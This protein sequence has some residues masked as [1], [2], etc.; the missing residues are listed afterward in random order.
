[1]P[2][3]SED[4][5]VGAAVHDAS[6]G[7]SSRF[8][9]TPPLARTAKTTVGIPQASVLGER[10]DELAELRATLLQEHVGRKQDRLA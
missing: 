9:L 8:R 10:P 7:I 6:L 3:R 4:G 5:T 2:R 1:V